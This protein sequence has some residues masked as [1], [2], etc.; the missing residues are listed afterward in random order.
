[1]I[2]YKKLAVIVTIVHVAMFELKIASRLREITSLPTMPAT[3]VR[4][5]G[6]VSVY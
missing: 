1:M 2:C 4:R 3:E 5:R 6:N